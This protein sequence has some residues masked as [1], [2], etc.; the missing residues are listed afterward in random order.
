[1]NTHNIQFHNEKQHFRIRCLLELS[2]KFRRGLKKE[3]ELAMVN[4]H[5]CSSY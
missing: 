1:M 4:E 2:E 5:R 3:F